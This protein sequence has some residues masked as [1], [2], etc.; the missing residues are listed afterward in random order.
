MPELTARLRLIA[1]IR[2]FSRNLQRGAQ[3]AKQAMNGLNTGVGNVSKGLN[4]AT[5]ASKGFFQTLRANVA[6]QI[7]A[8]IM[9]ATLY[10][11]L[12]TFRQTIGAAISELLKLDE[13]LRKVQ[14]ITK[15]S[16]ESIKALN[17]SLLRAAREGKLFGQTAGEIAAGMFEIVQSGF[18]SAEAFD[19]AL[20]AAQAA[21]TGFT[22]AA[23]AGKVITGAIKAFG[24]EAK[25]ARHV[26]NILFQTVDTGVV[27]FEE[28]ANGLGVA[29]APAAALNVPL[30]E[31][32]AAIGT[33]TI[34]GMPAQR[35]MTSLTRI[36]MAFLDPSDKAKAAAADMGFSLSA[37][38]VETHGLMGAMKLLNEAT[39]GSNE[40]LAD[41]FDRQRALVGAFTLLNDNATEYTS[42][43]GKMNGAQDDV[44]ALM[45]AWEE[46]QKALTVRLG[47]LR[48]QILSLVVVA[49]QP[50]S[51]VLAE[52]VGWFTSLIA[53]EFGLFAW[54]K[55]VALVS[56]LTASW[57]KFLGAIKGL[58]EEGGSTR[59]KLLFK[60]IF[61]TVE[62]GLPIFF[63]FLAAM[64]GIGTWA[65]KHKPVMLALAL[66][67]GAMFISAHPL[68]ATFQALL[69]I[70]G[71]ASENW[72]DWR[73]RVVSVTAAVLLA[74]IALNLLRQSFMLSTA[75][76]FLFRGATN[77]VGFFAT[78]IRNIG[79]AM[80]EQVAPIANFFA[81]TARTAKDA[82]THTG[83]VLRN[84]AGI[85]EKPVKI[86][87]TVTVTTIK[88]TTEVTA[89]GAGEVKKGIT[90]G[91]TKGLASGIG[92]GVGAAIILGI[93]KAFAV[94]TAIFG[95][96]A[97]GIAAAIVLAIIAVF[98][99]AFFIYKYRKEI[100]SAMKSLGGVL[101]DFFT[102]K[103]PE[104]MQP[105]IDGMVTF[106]TET[107]PSWASG[108]FTG[109]NLGKWFGRALMVAILLVFWPAVLVY[110]FRDKL[111]LWIEAIGEFLGDIPGMIAT[112]IGDAAGAI[113]GWIVDVVKWV[114]EF[115]KKVGEFE[116]AVVEFIAG[117]PGRIADFI[118]DNWKAVLDWLVDAAKWYAH[119]VLKV[120]EFYGKVA[121][122]VAGIPG[123][124]ADFIGDHWKD[125]VNFLIDP[126]AWWDLFKTLL[127][128][129]IDLVTEK[130]GPMLA[131]I[132]EG[133]VSGIKSGF[134]LAFEGLGGWIIDK[135]KAALGP[136]AGWLSKGV[137]FFKSFFG[138]VPGGMQD[139]IDWLEAAEGVT[140]YVGGLA[141][142]GERGAEMVRLPRGSDVVRNA[143]MGQALRGVRGSGGAGSAGGAG[144]NSVSAEV[145]ITTSMMKDFEELK[146]R[147][148]LAV[149]EQLDEAAARSNMANPRFGT[150]GAGVPRT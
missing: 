38:T 76:G 77:E 49:F 147:V 22:D 10:Q 116:L 110:K 81:T 73:V 99:A 86:A 8:G 24:M 117:L 115:E 57:M 51:K 128:E 109:E 138:A 19:I 89:K 58:M 143:D 40:K 113:I 82:A 55:N 23:T 30:E 125:I 32:G 142:V 79:R 102:E 48:A 47:I 65:V 137:G 120:V 90:G 25:D 70:V 63:R 140:N 101:K 12:I 26:A 107:L 93:I 146:R 74:V 46:R 97:V 35:A 54:I 36:M 62:K 44:G 83:K 69:I 135:A 18:D 118:G 43:L 122:F 42:I 131:D 20:V 139:V 1:D 61:V 127:Q 56:G 105:L 64:I 87:R 96:I 45:A 27:K 129:F 52:V 29:M 15:E 114:V 13:S 133:V 121:D 67:F 3:Q 4:G 103:L 59:F 84:L 21:A 149:D 34:K 31:L 98:I 130:I 94:A 6:T 28:L 68:L 136:I 150:T 14:S 60:G 88:K 144:G 95:G 39:G 71:Y 148:L 9:F 132:G 92:Q 123:A 78:A 141:L 100:W 41:V 112:L 33:M 108:F 2:D 5:K 106:F 50:L 11:A 53:D 145:N 16:D 72:G 17:D 7:K 37:Q 66:A 134:T 104:M 111:W 75:A 85:L 91:L 119:F 124:I 126:T 80:A